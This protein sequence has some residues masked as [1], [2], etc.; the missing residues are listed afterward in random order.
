MVSAAFTLLAEVAVMVATVWLPTGEVLTVNWPLEEPAGITMLS[1]TV[2][3]PLLL[4]RFTSTP[5]I[6]VAAAK[7][8]V[9]VEGLPPV[10]VLGL[11]VRLR[12]CPSPGLAG[13][14]VSAALTLFAEVAVMVAIVWLFTAVVFTVN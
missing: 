4:E 3:E 1:G 12:I 13:L 7:V 6:G 14:I 8:T 11:S 10:T 9:P 2:A 5:P